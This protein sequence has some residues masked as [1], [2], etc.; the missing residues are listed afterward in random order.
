V[1]RDIDAVAERV[2]R[3]AIDGTAEAITGETIPMEADTI[4]LHGDTPG[5][6]TLASAIKAR[7]QREGV[8]LARLDQLV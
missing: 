4:C 8:Q 6:V 3:I 2:V 1:I 7:L 5:A